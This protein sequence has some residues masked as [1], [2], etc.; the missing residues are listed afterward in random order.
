MNLEWPASLFFTRAQMHAGQD[1]RPA[2]QCHNDNH[3][4]AHAQ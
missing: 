4:V 2:H 3:R 1:E